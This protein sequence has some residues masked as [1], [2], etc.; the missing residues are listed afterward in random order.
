MSIVSLERGADLP[1]TTSYGLNDEPPIEGLLSIST[2]IPE[3]H[4]ELAETIGGLAIVTCEDIKTASSRA[5]TEHFAKENTPLPIRQEV[6]RVNRAIYTSAHAMLQAVH[7]DSLPEVDTQEIFP[8]LKL[9]ICDRDGKLTDEAI[10]STI[11]RIGLSGHFDHGRPRIDLN[12]ARPHRSY[13]FRIATEN[14]MVNMIT[15]LHRYRM[16]KHHDE[17]RIGHYDVKYRLSFAGFDV[18]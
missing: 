17:P 9:A 10:R 15:E 7:D 13:L 16:P 18:K 3:R 14:P 8:D 4:G 12:W 6:R 2:D 11:G 1:A 5:M